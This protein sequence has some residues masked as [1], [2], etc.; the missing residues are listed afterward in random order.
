MPSPALLGAVAGGAV[1]SG[2]GAAVGGTLGLAGGILRHL[3]R[4]RKDRKEHG[5]LGDMAA[6]A[7]IGGGVGM[8]ATGIPGAMAG[9]NIG[10]TLTPA[11]TGLR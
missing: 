3:L 8:L 2:A 5:L 4:N 11:I 1:T 9:A 6:G 10:K 7:G